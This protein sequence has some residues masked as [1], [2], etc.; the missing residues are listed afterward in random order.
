MVNNPTWEEL[1]PFGNYS[2]P[3]SETTSGTS[4]LPE[5]L[6]AWYDARRKSDQIVDAVNNGQLPQSALGHARQL[7]EE[8]GGDYDNPPESAEVA[9]TAGGGLWDDISSFL[10]FDDDDTDYNSNF[11]DLGQVL[12]ADGL[13]TGIRA[14]PPRPSTNTIVQQ[15]REIESINELRAPE[16]TPEPYDGPTYNPEPDPY[17]TSSPFGGLFQQ[18]AVYPGT[19]TNE[20][21]HAIYNEDDPSAL[22]GDIAAGYPFGGNPNAASFIPA[23]D[24][25]YPEGLRGSG[26][27]ESPV[28]RSSN[29]LMLD[30][31]KSA[32][33]NLLEGAKSLFNSISA[34]KYNAPGML[35]SVIS[36]PLSMTGARRTGMGVQ[37]INEARGTPGKGMQA[38]AASMALPLAQHMVPG[39]GLLGLFGGA[40]NAAGAF[41]DFDKSTDSNP[42]FDL[43][44]GMVA[45]DSTTPGGGGYQEGFKNAENM[46]NNMDPDMVVETNF[47]GERGF[48][49]AGEVAGLFEAMRTDV[50]QD[51]PYASPAD[52]FFQEDTPYGYQDS[53]YYGMT[54]DEAYGS[55][56]SQTGN[57]WNSLAAANP[58]LGYN[59]LTGL[60]QQTAGD[61][62]G[63][64]DNY[65]G[66]DQQQ[67]D[68]DAAQSAH[69][70]AMADG[71]YDG[72][73][74]GVGGDDWGAWGD[75]GSDAY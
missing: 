22:E 8:T 5:W 59:E 65:A 6:Q 35:E 66:S 72:D 24:G 20:A 3:T 10:G 11:D 68:I 58:G 57:A 28:D 40:L 26:Y 25:P 14:D 37:S 42:F 19:A 50:D 52:Y 75:W 21:A 33:N 46:L 17:N 55:L 60:A 43:D 63:V 53:Q 56:S 13:I 7:I 27:I 73:A 41:H 15:H 61:M 39:A 51:N 16:F 12:S 70:A 71:S 47:Q 29:P 44:T 64:G 48:G 34:D 2:A 69:D 45:W 9:A 62:Y 38:R 23:W 32:G 49:K 18:G 31:I 4:E 54:N 67:A 74:D 36:N 30:D 1:N